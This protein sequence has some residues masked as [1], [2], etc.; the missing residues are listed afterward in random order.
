MSTWNAM[1]YDAKDNLLRV[2]KQQAAGMFA[3]AAAPGAWE[4]PTA[5]PQWQVRDIIGHIIDVTE[6]YFV[7]FD[8]ARS[9]TSVP[10]ALGTR[11]VVVLRDGQLVGERYAEGFDAS[12]PQ[13][14]AKFR[15]EGDDPYCRERTGAAIA[16]ENGKHNRGRSQK[17]LFPKLTTGERLTLV[18]EEFERQDPM[19]P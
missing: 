9:G 7:G 3:L 18:F 5:C 2:V 16:G 11:G 14:E 4:A 8:A 10:D 13:L 19:P 6:S 1:N 17:E 15:L 12:I